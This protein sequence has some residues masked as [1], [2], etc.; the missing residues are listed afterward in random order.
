MGFMRRALLVSGMFVLVWIAPAAARAGGDAARD[1]ALTYRIYYGGFEVLRLTV[2]LRMAPENYAL[3]MKFR[4]LGVIGALFPWTMRAYSHGLL[5]RNG[6][7]PVAAGHRN[8][9]RGNQRWVELRYPSRGPIVVDA[10]PPEEGDK[11]SPESLIGAIDL[12]SAVVAMTR[13]LDKDRNCGD[14]LPVFDGRRRYDLLFKGLGDSVIRRSGYSAFAGP[15][16]KCRVG[17]DRLAGF[18][19]S[20]KSYGGWGA[21]D[22]AASVFMGR[23]FIDAPPVPVRIEIET[24]WG[25]VIAHLT[26]AKLA[27]DGTTR[28]LARRR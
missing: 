12:A 23:P 28:D 24:R 5:T 17:M 25:D 26:G 18:R 4:T 20:H 2:D 6:V 14:R 19:K 13:T 9:W 22:R 10:H 16:V 15:V 1:L 27:T 8:S 11:P 7:R 3:E 21:A